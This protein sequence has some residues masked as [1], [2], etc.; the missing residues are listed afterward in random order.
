MKKLVFV[1]AA[2]AA[3]ILA[4]PASTI[5]ASAQVSV[6]VGERGVGVRIGELGY[7]ERSDYRGDGYRHR[8]A[9]GAANC[10]T[11]REKIVTPR[12]RVIYKTQRICD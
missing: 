9:Y 11:I 12:G 10:R 1:A 3:V 7:R 2:L 6:G 5:P 4:I 8:R